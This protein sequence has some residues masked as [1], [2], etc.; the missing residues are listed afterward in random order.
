[1][2]Q[3]M[4]VRILRTALLFAAIALF[5]TVLLAEPNWCGT[6]TTP[7]SQPPPPPRCTNGP[8][9]AATGA[10]SGNSCQRCTGSPCYPYSGGYTTDA[11]DLL[12][13]T[14]GLPLVV[15]RHYESV[16]PIDRGAGLGWTINLSARLYMATYFYA[17]PSTYLQEADVSLPDGSQYRFALNAN[18]S[19]TPPADRHD[20]LVRNG[21]GSFDLTMVDGPAVYHFDSTGRLTT[22]TDQFGNA[23]TY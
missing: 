15:S 19:F 9:G 13:P 10:D 21:D 7:R 2:M 14:S 1:M 8:S 5:P 23:L 6:P 11:R 12:I 18:G 20:T 16:W 3:F 17:A 4:I 22:L